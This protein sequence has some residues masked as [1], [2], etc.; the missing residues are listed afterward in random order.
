MSRTIVSWDVGIKNLAYCII[1]DTN[2]KF[3]ILKWDLIDLRDTN[4]LKCCEYKKV[5]KELVKC[6]T[7]AKFCIVINN[8]TIGY[9]G[10]H[11]NKYKGLEVDWK[12]KFFIKEKCNVKC[13]YEGKKKCERNS[14]YKY[15]DSEY[16]CSTHYKSV[17]NRIEKAH[18]LKK[19]KRKGCMSQTV[20]SLGERLCTKLDKIKE[21]LMVDEILIENQPTLKNPTMKT[22]ST[23]LFNYF[24]V[25]GIVDKDSTKSTITNIKFMSPS[26]K[27]KV[28]ENQTMEVMNKN[29][30]PEKKYKLTKE[31]AIKY[32]KILIKDMPEKLKHLDKYKK[33]DDLC[34]AFLQGYYY[35]YIKKS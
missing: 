28:N 20:F 1:K 11:K 25:R 19:Y 29:K 18:T 22:V 26:N 6:E 17:V 12:D 23:F 13:Y 10:R 4:E 30:D 16:Y 14:S 34:D 21:L 15:K 3:E 9:C 24:I 7:K 31:L 35:M 5:K 32:T 33:K 2:G 27:L 8:E